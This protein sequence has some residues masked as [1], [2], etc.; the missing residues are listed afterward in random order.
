[1]EIFVPVIPTSNFGGYG[2][3][4]QDPFGSCYSGRGRCAHRSPT[5]SRLRRGHQSCSPA[6]PM[7]PRAV[8]LVDDMDMSDWITPAD[9]ISAALLLGANAEAGEEKTAPVTGV[10]P[11]A[12][13]DNN[14]FEVK[15]NVSDYKPEELNVKILNGVVTIEG[16]HEETK[17]HNDEQGKEGGHKEFV[18]CQFTRS[19]AIPKNVIEEQLECKLTEDGNLIVRAPLKAIEPAPEQPAVK[20]IP[21]DVEGKKDAVATE[22]DKKKPLPP[23]EES[24]ANQT[25]QEVEEDAKN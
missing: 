22:D 2:P 9:L 20:S 19:F 3:W 21:I 12:N 24:A 18:S 8:R 1:M 17:I 11:S 23:Q 16:K 15:L 14:N 25:S 5:L 13:G 4:S 7:A 6:R 10:P